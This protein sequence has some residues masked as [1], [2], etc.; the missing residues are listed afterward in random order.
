MKSVSLKWLREKAFYDVVCEDFEEI[1]GEKETIEKIVET[2]HENNWRLSRRLSRTVTDFKFKLQRLEAHL[3]IIRPRLTKSMIKEGANIQSL[4]DAA[5]RLASK[6]GL[7]RIVRILIKNGADV[8]AN[9]EEALISAWRNCHK[10]VK[11]ILIA[12]GADEKAIDRE[13]ERIRDVLTWRDPF[14]DFD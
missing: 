7:V 11:E 12:N 2:L 5:L 4:N 13:C 14:E 3:L 10:K 6:K 1:F 8:H 9:R